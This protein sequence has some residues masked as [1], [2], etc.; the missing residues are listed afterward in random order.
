VCQIYLVGEKNVSKFD[1][2]K[3]AHIGL[4]GSP[5]FIMKV[6]NYLILS[7]MQ[8]ILFS[9]LNKLIKV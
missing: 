6:S 5:E 8:A 2:V 9:V 3:T 7:K 1:E 4:P